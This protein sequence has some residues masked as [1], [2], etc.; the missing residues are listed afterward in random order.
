MLIA[1]FFSGLAASGGLIIAI[2]AQNA[3]VLRQGLKKEH[4]GLV[5]AACIFGDVFCTTLGIAGMGTLV[6]AHPL[7]LE[8]M[9]WGGAAFLFAYGILAL[10]RALA[11]GAALTAARPDAAPASAGRVLA[12]CLGFTFLNP[13]VYL[14]TVVLLGSISA[15]FEGAQRWLFAAGC[16]CASAVWFL[17]L[18]FGARLLLPLF[19]SP[20]AWQ[21]LDGLVALF[22]FGLAAALALHPLA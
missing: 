18:G 8:V 21:A 10:R 15:Q 4:V 12:A 14:D 6:K 1:P 13:H 7:A 19:Q 11:G 2:G 17:G 22:M 3:F 20:K 16:Y 5:A 9:R